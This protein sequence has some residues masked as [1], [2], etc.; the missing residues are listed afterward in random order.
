LLGL[1]ADLTGITFARCRNNRIVIAASYV[2]PGGLDAVYESEPPPE[3]TA[4]G[5]AQPL[6]AS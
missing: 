1:P 3:T 4:S 5:Q 2:D 6:R